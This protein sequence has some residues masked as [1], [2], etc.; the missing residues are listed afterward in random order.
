MSSGAIVTFNDPRRFG[1]MKI[2]ARKAIDAEPL[3]AALGPEPLGNEF[4]AAMLARACA[5]KKTSLKAALLDQK[6]VAG[7]G[8][9]YVCEA[10]T[11]RGSRPSAS[12]RPSPARPA[13]RTSAPNGWWPASKPCL[14][15]RSR[16]A[17]LHCAITSAPTANSACSSIISGST[18]ARAKVP[19]AR[20]RRHGQ[21]HRA[22]RPFDVLLPEC[23]K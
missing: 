21:A 15:T 17:G 2:V 5:G 13:R 3:L 12:P 9:I 19:D 8:N 18:T 1:F 4:D 7:L 23:Q 20:L 22:E 16:P 6:V 10:L 14:R 11:A